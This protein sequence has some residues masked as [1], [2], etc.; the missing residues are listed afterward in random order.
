[1]LSSFFFDDIYAICM[2]IH[3]GFP[4]DFDDLSRKDKIHL[5]GLQLSDITEVYHNLVLLSRGSS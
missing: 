4:A 5:K 3:L 2:K 1:M